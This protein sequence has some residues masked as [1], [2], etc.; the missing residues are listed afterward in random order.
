MLN[1]KRN[2]SLASLV[3]SLGEV[4]VVPFGSLKHVIDS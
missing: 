4:I 3:I 2:R 1:L